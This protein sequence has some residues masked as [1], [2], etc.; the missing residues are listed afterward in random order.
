M[1]NTEMKIGTVFATHLTAGASIPD[2]AWETTQWVRAAATEA[3]WSDEQVTNAT[4]IT[5]MLIAKWVKAAADESLK[6]TR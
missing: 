3:G 5:A 2:A 1:N 6:E 4:A